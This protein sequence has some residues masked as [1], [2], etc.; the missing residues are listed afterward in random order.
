MEDTIKKLQSPG[1]GQQ[2]AETSLSLSLGGRLA[3]DKKQMLDT[4]VSREERGAAV[5]DALGASSAL[6]T[7][8]THEA[9][10]QKLKE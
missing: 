8:K 7:P 2:L 9:R 3:D 5:A 6:G 1:I 10:E 4:E